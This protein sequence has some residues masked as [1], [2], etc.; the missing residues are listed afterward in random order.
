MNE[1]LVKFTDGGYI[2]NS[3]CR[4][5]QLK[6]NFAFYKKSDSY[7][8]RLYYCD[9]TTLEKARLFEIKKLGDLGIDN[10]L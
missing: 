8:I 6:G 2:R 5:E 10:P 3:N 1:V 4:T 9:P 7:I